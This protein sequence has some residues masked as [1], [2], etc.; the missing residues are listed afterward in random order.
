M[1]EYLE[2]F[3]L[4]SVDDTTLLALIN[5]AAIFVKR[6]E[7]FLSKKESSPSPPLPSGALYHV[8]FL[9]ESLLN[10]LKHSLPRLKYMPTGVRQPGVCLFGEH[11]YVYNKATAKLKPTPFKE[12]SSITRTLE[13][14]NKKLKT[15]FN[16]VLVNK[17]HNKNTSLNWHRDDEPEIDQ[18]EAIASLSIGA[19]RKFIIA[20]SPE[21]G[22][23]GY[24]SSTQMAENSVF[25]MEAGFQEKH[26]HKVDS[27]QLEAERGVRYSLTFRKLLPDKKRQ[28]PQPAFKSSPI[29]TKP[30][31]TN[32]GFSGDTLEEK[33]HHKCFESIVIGSS[34]T[35]GLDK[36]RLSKPG[37]CFEVICHPGA[38]VR[39]IIKSFED[40]IKSG[41]ICRECIQNVFLICGGNDVENIRNEAGLDDLICSFNNLICI[42]SDHFLNAMINVVSL[43]PRRLK[44]DHHLS[45]ISSVNESLIYECAMFDNCKY[46]DIFSNFL[47]YKKRFYTNYE[48]HLNENLYVNDK[49]HFSKKG[50]SV[51]AKVIM[52]VTYNPY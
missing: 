39:T 5:S 49:L 29:E 32:D 50:Y 20:D 41:T 33:T 14:V 26:V 48:V 44:D 31:P 28:K 38:K 47:K 37:K 27:G 18:S 43:I 12:G 3:K 17:Y 52:G 23:R 30:H 1:C 4:D 42:I 34:L 36:E 35:R 13:V 24:F 6:A 15:N 2:S 25:I 51:L 11:T 46:I 21:D 10:D 9:E 45:R 7:V 16:S 19:E 22:D 40:I 8:G